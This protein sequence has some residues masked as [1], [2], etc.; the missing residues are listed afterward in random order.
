MPGVG[1]I[2]D[3][4]MFG[5]E[6]DLLELRLRELGDVVDHFVICE[7]ARTHTG[8]PKPLYFQENRERF[9]AWGDQIV[10]I[11]AELDEHASHA[12]R[13]E[14]QQRRS[15]RDVLRARVAPDDAVI[16]G[17]V[18]EF[19]DRDAVAEVA[20]TCRAPVT[21]GMPHSIYYANWWMPLPWYAPPIFTRGSQLGAPHVRALLGEPHEQW[22]GFRQQIIDGCGVHVSY[23][24]GAEAVRRKF[25]GHPDMY[26]NAPR[27]LRPGWIERCIEYGVH[28]EGWSVLRRV[29]AAEMPPLLK[30]MYEDAP[31]LFDFSPAPDERARR[32]FCGYAWLRRSGRLPD[33]TV[34]WLDTHTH[35]VTEGIPSQAFRAIDSARRAR[36]RVWDR[37]E[38]PSFLPLESTLRA[39]RTLRKHPEWVNPIHLSLGDLV[40]TER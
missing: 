34:E 9:S 21:L 11:V 6:L 27:F 23:G 2:W 26:L 17:D 32:A 40:A 39:R 8:Q 7:A 35:A 30:R 29:D 12:W 38:P 1:Q 24:G 15:M 3:C 22:D 20:K 28:F 4:F 13:R 14:E 10:H 36:R 19:L 25:K 37:P 33:R 16:I 5:G 18:D 31:Q